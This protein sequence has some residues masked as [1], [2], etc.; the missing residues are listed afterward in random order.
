MAAA[1]PPLPHDH[2]TDWVGE[3]ERMMARSISLPA[4]ARQAVLATL[5]SIEA[6]DGLLPRTAA[7]ARATLA[8][9]ACR[10]TREPSLVEEVECD[11]WVDLSDEREIR[12]FQ[13]RLKVGV[14]VTHRL[15]PF[16]R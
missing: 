8:G 1:T 9:L 15:L 11:V 10:E 6:E 14:N 2:I 3:L 16:G 13:R 7:E 4:A 12:R 5:D